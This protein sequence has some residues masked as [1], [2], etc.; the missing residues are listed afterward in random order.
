MPSAVLDFVTVRH[1]VQTT[2]RGVVDWSPGDLDSHSL[3]P[4]PTSCGTWTRRVHPLNLCF[5]IHGIRPNSFLMYEMNR[6]S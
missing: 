5:Q 2:T 3:T 1:R 6:D 4:P